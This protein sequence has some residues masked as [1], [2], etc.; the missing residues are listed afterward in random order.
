MYKIIIFTIQL[1]VLL[2]ILTLIFSNPFIISLDISNLKYSFSSNIFFGI[3]IAFLL[4]IYLSIYI[5]LKSRL[6]ISK[7]ILRNKYKKIEKGYYYFVEAMIA[8]ANKD[9]KNASISHRKMNN[10]L[11]G[12]QS[13]SLLLRSEVFKIEN[14][15]PDL[16]EVYEEMIKSKK[17]ESLGYRGLM[18]INLKNQDYH[19]AFLY[20]EKLFYLNPYIDKLYETLVYI[21]A[22]TKN[23]NQ[24][25]NISDKAFS[26]KIISRDTLN[27]NKSIGLYEIAK[28]KSD[29]NIKESTKNIIKALELK[30]NFVPY[31]K[32]HL[33]LITK[34]NNI[35]LIKKM[36]KKYWY[37]NPNSDLR[38][39]IKNILIANKLDKISFI[40]EITNK[41]ENEDS[42]KLLIYFAIRNK[43][44]KIARESIIGIIGSNP[45]REVCL[46]MADIE[47]GEN[48]DKQKSDAWIL[49]SQNA[50]LE[51]MWICKITNKTQPEWDSLSD[52]GHFNSLVWSAPKMLNN[53]LN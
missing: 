10:F 28:I 20:G 40:S 6:T 47:L 53:I 24:V 7:Y 51:N 52:S 13:L 38:M 34:T 18:E 33:E 39:I 12:D 50:T 2:F 4:L 37:Q 31:I 9:H 21:A 45:S 42:K 46:F 27:E 41:F 35:K 22:K 19:H 43:E 17:T 26:K 3:V 29:S 25:I 48:N 14:K 44:W 8:L 16:I 32:L 23:W 11:K 5:Y 1:L 36:I 30:K 15:F 49:R